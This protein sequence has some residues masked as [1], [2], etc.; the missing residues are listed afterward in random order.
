MAQTTTN[1]DI[2][3]VSGTLYIGMDLGC[4]SWQLALG[5]G[6]K[7]RMVAVDRKD[8]ERGKADFLAEIAK[9]KQRFDLDPDAEVVVVHEAGRDGFWIVRW[10][11]K[12]DIRC[13]VVDPA[14]LPVD[15]RAKQ[16]KTDAID[17]R[18]LL[19]L[20]VRHE[21]GQAPLH[22]VAVPTPEE[23]DARELGRALDHLN[24]SRTSLAL[25]MESLLWK[26][27]IVMTYTTGCEDK[28]NEVKTGCGGPLGE[29]LK[30]ECARLC[31]QIHSMDLDICALEDQRQ[32][33]I[34]Q[35]A[36]PTEQIA[37]NLER[38]Y[39]IGPIGASTLAFELFGWRKF[40]NAKKLGS[41]LGL[42]PTPFDSGRKDREQG[43][44]KAG[45]GRLRALLIQLGWG[46]LRYQPESALSQW[47]ATRNSAGA[48]RKKRVDIVAVA[49][50]LAVELWRYVNTGTVPIGAV[51]KP[52]YHRIS[53][54]SP[55]GCAVRQ[56]ARRKALAATAVPSAA[57]A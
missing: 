28:L 15:R 33:Q 24:G 5:D 23:E 45:P 17:A 41:F 40:A 37:H 38:L 51:L 50:K 3:P 7:H 31:R 44:S 11:G 4:D 32:R 2:T 39:G 22:L 19:D 1:R 55:K 9:G 16:R 48:K 57:L 27:G 20:L 14:S 29:Y 43:I 18:G 46:W 53:P 12:Q 34:E 10:L 56:L 42:C 25:R 49:R 35:P 36:S 54:V 21:L 6:Q 8:L 47:F 52:D 30:G 26:E 13:H